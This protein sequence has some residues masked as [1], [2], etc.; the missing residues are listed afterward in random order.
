MTS[1]P[2][3]AQSLV[4]SPV[5][6]HY[7]AY[8]G[9]AYNQLKRDVADTIRALATTHAGDVPAAFERRVREAVERREFWRPFAELPAVAIDTAEIARA[10][11]A[12][13]EGVLERLRAK[14]AA[15]LEALA[16]DDAMRQ[17]AAAHCRS[18]TL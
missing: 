13:R 18:P 6:D 10:W 8:F 1:C 14:Q 3:C 17:P 15:P 16:V 7:R 2:F 9:E 11:K 4:V 5:I 12:A